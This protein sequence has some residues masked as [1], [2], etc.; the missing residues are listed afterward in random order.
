M[1]KALIA[2]LFAASVQAAT[3]CEEH[4]EST[5]CVART[6]FVHAR[7]G[8]MRETELERSILLRPEFIQS[9]LQITRER[10][11]ADLVLEIR[12]KPFTSEFTLTVIDQHRKIVLASD[13][14]NSL[15][16]HIEPKLAKEFA[17]MLKRYR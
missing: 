6:I 5:W 9:G 13:H 1:K 10:R 15:G 11:D 16:G 2:L 8:F 4:P 14:A 12:R 7:S 3:P 17:R